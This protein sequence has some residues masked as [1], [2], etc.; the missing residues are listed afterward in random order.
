MEGNCKRIYDKYYGGDGQNESAYTQ[1]VCAQLLSVAEIMRRAVARTGVLT[2]NSL[3]VGA[4]AVRN[5]FFYDATVPLRWSLP[6]PGRAVQ[7]QG[8]Q[9]LH[10][11]RLE[12]GPVEVPVPRVPDRT[13]RSWGRARAA[14]RTCATPSSSARRPAGSCGPGCGPR[15]PSWSPKGVMSTWP[16]ST[17]SPTVGTRSHAVRPDTGGVAARRYDEPDELRQIRAASDPARS[18]CTGRRA[19]RRG[20]GR[21][22]VHRIGVRLHAGQAVRDRPTLAELRAALEPAGDVAA[23]RLPDRGRHLVAARRSRASGPSWCASASATSLPTTTSTTRCSGCSCSSS[24]ARP[25][26]GRTCCSSGSTTCRCC[27]TFGP[28][29]TL[30]ANSALAAL[31][32]VPAAAVAARPVGAAFEP[33]RRAVRRADPGRRLRLRVPR[34]S[35]ARPPSWRGATQA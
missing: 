17:T 34:A 3:I 14:A 30:L 32:P 15:R 23:A 16:R 11:R 4:D 28:E 21:G 10:R 12:L 19:R 5:D 20:A 1:I 8:V 27:A 35:G 24:T 13:G 18:T 9:P 33:R 25:S 2:G 31:E 7:D 26:P 29:R 6:R 22:R